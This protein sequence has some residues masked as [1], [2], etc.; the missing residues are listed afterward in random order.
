MA[1][2]HKPFRRLETRVEFV[3]GESLT[4]LR[5]GRRLGAATLGGNRAR[6]HLANRV[7]HDDVLATQAEKVLAAR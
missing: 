2:A 7:Q 4:R 3:S 5:C 6:R 1:G